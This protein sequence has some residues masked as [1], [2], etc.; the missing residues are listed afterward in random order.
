MCYYS[1]MKIKSWDFFLRSSIQLPDLEM[2]LGSEFNIRYS[3]SLSADTL[4]K[5]DEPIAVM[6]DACVYYTYEESRLL[7]NCAAPRAHPATVL[8]IRSY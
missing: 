5:E 7:L 2:C 1:T 6:A 8:T 3:H 4:S